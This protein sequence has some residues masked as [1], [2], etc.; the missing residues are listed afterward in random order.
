VEV[1]GHLRALAELPR[2]NRPR[3]PVNKS[4]WAPERSERGI[5]ENNELPLLRMNAGRPAL[6]LVT[7]VT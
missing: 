6:S 4:E 7:V 5:E 3:F 2:G 1:S